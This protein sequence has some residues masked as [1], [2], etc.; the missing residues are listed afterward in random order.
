MARLPVEYRGW[1]PV[2]IFESLPA[3]LEVD[4]HPVPIV[5]VELSH[6]LIFLERA[7]HLYFVVLEQRRRRSR[8]DGGQNS[9]Q[10]EQCRIP[11]DLHD[12]EDSLSFVEAQ[13]SG[14]GG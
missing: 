11:G 1:P 3:R 7:D 6:H 2:L 4:H 5:L 14:L 8:W 12:G 10:Q 13:I 9:A